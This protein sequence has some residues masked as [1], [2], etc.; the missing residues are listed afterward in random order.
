M[1]DTTFQKPNTSDDVDME[2]I[3]AY[4]FEVPDTLF[5]EK[6][7]RLKE[8][9]KQNYG[10]EPTSHRAGRFGV[11][12]RTIDWL[13]KNNFVVDTSVV[14]SGDYSR[15]KGKEKEGPSFFGKPFNPY[16]GKEIKTA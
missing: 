7:G 5:E 4:Q 13:I 2:W 1:V 12:Q 3:H 9:I 16:N 8:T 15:Y 11:D 6:A 10:I 14:P